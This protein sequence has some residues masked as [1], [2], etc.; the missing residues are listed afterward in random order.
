MILPCVSGMVRSQTRRQR[1]RPASRRD[2][3]H[4]NAVT[5]EHAVLRLLIVGL[6]MAVIAPLV[7]AIAIGRRPPRRRITPLPR[8]RAS[9]KLRRLRTTGP[10]RPRSLSRDDHR[11]PKTGRHASPS[12][13]ATPRKADVDRRVLDLPR[14]CATPNPANRTTADL[15]EFHLGMTF[16]HGDAVVPLL[17]QPEDYDTLRLADGVTVE[18]PRRHDAVR[19]VPRAAASRL[20]ARR[21]RRHER[22]LGPHPRPAHPQQLRRLPRPPRA[23]F[24]RMQPT[25]KPEDRF[26]HP[27]PAEGEHEP[28]HGMS[29]KP[30][31][32]LPVLGRMSRRTGAEGRRR[33]ARRGRVR[34]RDLAPPP[35]L[36]E[37]LTAEEFMQRHYKEL[38]RRR[39]NGGHCA[40]R[41]RTRSEKYGADVTSATI[42]SPSPTRSSST[43]ST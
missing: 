26:L 4:G 31:V 13:G 25:F 14:P 11:P 30:D 36:G 8:S 2:D 37:E 34:R 38:S 39:T 29:E 15:D 42:P 27:A 6:G 35:K 41:R 10:R 9:R 24:P 1:H 22:L 17:P 32:S 12:T 19:P 16:A 3:G 23:A 20:P 33:D 18:L 43:R 40:A 5:I 7:V 21:P 28:D